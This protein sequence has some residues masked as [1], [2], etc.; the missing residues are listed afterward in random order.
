MCSGLTEII[1]CN[2]VIEPP[3]PAVHHALINNPQVALCLFNYFEA[4]FR[5]NPDWDDPVIREEQ[6]LF[7]LR[8]QL[9]ESIASVSDINDDRILRTLFNLI[10]ATMRCNFHLRRDSGGLF[11]RL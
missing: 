6:A 1:I 8:L 3:E 5:P 7:P 9:L 2:W 10:D 4:R 11:C